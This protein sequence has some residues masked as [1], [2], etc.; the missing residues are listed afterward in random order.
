MRGS[1]KLAA[2]RVD[3]RLHIP[4]GCAGVVCHVG[5]HRHFDSPKHTPCCCCCRCVA[6]LQWRAG[7]ECGWGGLMHYEPY[8]SVSGHHMLMSSG[9]HDTGQT[10]WGDRRACMRNWR[11]TCMYVRP[12]VGVDVQLGQG[13]RWYAVCSTGGTWAPHTQ[14]AAM[15]GKHRACL[16]VWGARYFAWRGCGVDSGCNASA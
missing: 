14:S 9:G 8:S 11:H 2:V 10:R 15:Q 6:A 1:Y 4:P 13:R 16:T 5:A 3:I 7:L 12:G